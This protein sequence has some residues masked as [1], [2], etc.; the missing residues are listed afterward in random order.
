MPIWKP[1]NEMNVRL[2]NW[3]I[4]E[5]EFENGDVSRHLIGTNYNNHEARVSSE[6]KMYDKENNIC[7]TR[8]GRMY[9]LQGEPLT[10]ISG[11]ALY[12]WA[13]WKTFNM[14]KSHKLVSHEYK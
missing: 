14:V 5:C 9:S 10:H 11:D 8:S 3:L 6:I 7:I 12:V 1:S 4:V 13:K 2:F